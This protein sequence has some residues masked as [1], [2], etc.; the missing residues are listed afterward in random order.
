MCQIADVPIDSLEEGYPFV[1]LI[2][3]GN[4]KLPRLYLVTVVNGYILPIPSA[5]EGAVHREKGLVG[6][7]HR[8]DDVEIRR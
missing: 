5:L 2:I 1:V 6:G 4:H 3:D 7:V 8:S